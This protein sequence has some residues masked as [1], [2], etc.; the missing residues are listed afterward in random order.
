MDLKSPDKDEEAANEESDT[1]SS[2]T[3]PLDEKQERN[4][5]ERWFSYVVGRKK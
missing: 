4:P 1:D 3:L 2:E 5:I